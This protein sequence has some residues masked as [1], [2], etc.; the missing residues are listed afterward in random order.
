MTL[1]DHLARLVT[2]R[3]EWLDQHTGPLLTQGLAVD[4]L[5]WL[6]SRAVRVGATNP[7]GLLRH[8]LE[9]GD[10][11]AELAYR[12]ATTAQHGDEANFVPFDD[13][14]DGRTPWAYAVLYEDMPADEAAARWGVP[15][16]DVTDAV[17]RLRQEMRRFSPPQPARWW[18]KGGCEAGSQVRARC[19]GGAATPTGAGLPR[20][21]NKWPRGG[22]DG[23]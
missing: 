3:P 11:T 16:D 15:V 19:G 13:A 12:G 18:R 1:R 4:D 2:T 7:R 20:C 10:W 6:A 23:E 9:L 17:L 8:W 14:E 5:E 22:G 21:H